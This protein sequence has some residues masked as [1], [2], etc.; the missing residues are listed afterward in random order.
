MSPGQLGWLELPLGLCRR[1]TGALFP[2]GGAV[3]KLE[4][5][6]SAGLMCP[7][8]AGS[9]GAKARRVFSCVKVL[10][11]LGTV[12]IAGSGITGSARGGLTRAIGFLWLACT[13]D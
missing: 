5:T 8:I 4:L 6:F 1:D 11:L 13:R 2:A 10:R 7:G 12:L 3:A 9:R